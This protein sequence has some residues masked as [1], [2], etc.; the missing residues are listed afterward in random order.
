[1]AQ[2][3]KSSAHSLFISYMRDETR[4]RQNISDIE[5]CDMHEWSSELEKKN[6]FVP[7][8]HPTL[9]QAKFPI[10]IREIG[11][12]GL[13]KGMEDEGAVRR[14]MRQESE[15]GKYS[16]SSLRAGLSL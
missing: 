3:L 11:G 15:L 14:E 7:P 12:G 16:S 5:S 6:K 10:T 2:I 1:M 9:C 4:A 8:R 13:H